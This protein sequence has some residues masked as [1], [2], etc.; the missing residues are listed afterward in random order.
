MSRLPQCT[1]AE[2]I[3]VLERLGWKFRNASGSHYRYKHPSHPG[4]VIV[5]FHRRDLKRGTLRSVLKQA[6][7]PEEEFLRLLRG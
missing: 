7:I 3:R 6:G 4:T 1:P 2:V 5:P